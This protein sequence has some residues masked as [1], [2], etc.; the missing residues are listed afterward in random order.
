MTNTSD[1]QPIFVTN[2][3]TG[4][5]VAARLEALGHAVRLGSRTAHPAFDWTDRSTWAPALAGTRAAYVAYHPD[6]AAPGSL[7]DIAA[8]ARMAAEAGLIRIV[9][10]SG[11]GEE[12]ARQAEDAVRSSGLEWT[13]VRASW[14]MQN[15]TEGNFA[16]DVAAGVVALP[17]GAV[18]EPFVDADD[19]ADV[20][21]AA[22]TEDGHAGQ[23]YEVTGPRLMTFADAVA[24]LGAAIDRELHFICVPMTT[25]ANTLA[26]YEVPGE[27]IDLLGY[28]FTEVLD[29]RN[30]S[31]GD[32]VWQA[33]GRAPRDFADFAS[34]HARVAATS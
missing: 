30:A 29:G 1:T 22:L 24:E 5:R 33:L 4:S 18:L 9:L 8:F 32:G 16:D 15:F 34:A 2:G 20:A 21:V 10:L 3:K 23:V 14:F 28:L 19:I 31:R 17:V 13:V 12:E 11:R 25:Y 26:T 7:A 6:L 27:V